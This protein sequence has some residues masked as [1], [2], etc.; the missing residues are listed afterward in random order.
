[1]FASDD[2]SSRKM[3]S[4]RRLPNANMSEHRLYGSPLITSGAVQRQPWVFGSQSLISLRF[5]LLPPVGKTFLLKDRDIVVIVVQD[6]VSVDV[7]EGTTYR[8]NF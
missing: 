3:I 5:S 4:Y 2:G 6:L 1:M 7:R 8:E